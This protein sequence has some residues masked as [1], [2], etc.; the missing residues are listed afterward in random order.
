MSG[1]VKELILLSAS[2]LI[3]YN[4]NASS[5][6]LN[7]FVAYK[8]ILYDWCSD[9]ELQILFFIIQY[10]NHHAYWYHHFSHHKSLATEKIPDLTTA[11]TAFPIFLLEN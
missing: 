5:F 8:K 11:D 4:I 10:F 2:T 1:L 7:H 9:S 3:Y 6:I